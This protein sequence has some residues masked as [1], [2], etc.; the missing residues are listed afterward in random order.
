MSPHYVVGLDLGQSQDPTGL[1]V[2][3]VGGSADALTYDVGQIERLPLG[4]RY[5]AIVAHV[6]QVVADLARPVVVEER[7]ERGQPERRTVVPTVDLV[8][9]FTGCGRPVADMLVDANPAARLVLVTITGGDVVTRGDDGSYR[10]PKRDL[11]G[12]VQVLLQEGRLRIAEALPMTPALTQELT[13]FR[14]KISLTGHDSYGAGEDWRSAPHDDLVLALALA[15]WFG[16]REPAQPSA[17]PV[18]IGRA[19]DWGR[20][21]STTDTLFRH[22]QWK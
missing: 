20:V 3:T 18:G 22:T 6:C 10:V 19:P 12:V 4:S 7:P 9:D 16:E 15:C 17:P 21:P 14:V 2:A 8:V 11:A 1:I 5:P 13:G